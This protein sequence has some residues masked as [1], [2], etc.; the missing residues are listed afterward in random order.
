MF[1]DVS[2]TGSSCISLMPA[3]QQT[4]TRRLI[5]RN[6]PTPTLRRVR[7]LNTG[8]ASPLPRQR[9]LR[10]TG[11]SFCT[12]RAGSRGGNTP[13]GCS[14]E[15]AGLCVLSIDSTANRELSPRAAVASLAS[16]LS[17]RDSEAIVGMPSFSP[18]SVAGGAS[19]SDCWTGEA[20][21]SDATGALSSA[22]PASDF[23]S[24]V[25]GLRE[26]ATPSGCCSVRLPPSS[27][28]PT[29]LPSTTM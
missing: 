15:T 26:A 13:L 3:M 21:Q 2:L 19:L 6:S 4:S 28:V 16:S 25:D 14:S 12:I 22:A 20:A 10:N 24:I 9:T 27:M 17:L 23:S 7:R 29:P 18:A 11:P 8:T 5:S 1:T